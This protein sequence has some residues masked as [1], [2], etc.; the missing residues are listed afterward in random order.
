VLVVYF[1]VRYERDLNGPQSSRHAQQRLLGHARSRWKHENDHYVNGPI[2][3]EPHSFPSRVFLLAFFPSAVCLLE[4]LMRVR[5]IT[6]CQIERCIGYWLGRL[7]AIWQATVMTPEKMMLTNLLLCVGGASLAL[8]DIGSIS[9]MWAG[10]MT[11]GAFMASQFATAIVVAE[12]KAGRISGIEIGV[13]V[14]GSGLGQMIIPFVAATLF[15]HS[16]RS[17]FYLLLACTCVELVLFVLLLYLVPKNISYTTLED[18]LRHG[19]ISEV[20]ENV[21]ASAAPAH[22]SR[23]SLGT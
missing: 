1:R 19:S 12:K 4:I 7:I 8:V 18:G 9:L 10:T 5:F 17:L 13:F 21:V 6:M 2:Y 14:T 3:Y 22:T 23:S 15:Q 11:F 20:L 16:A